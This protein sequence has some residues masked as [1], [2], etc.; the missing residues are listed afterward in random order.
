MLSD[1][2]ALSDPDIERFLLLRSTLDKNERDEIPH[3]FITNKKDAFLYWANIYKQDKPVF[4]T[5]GMVGL[6]LMPIY[7]MLK[8]IFM[9]L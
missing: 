1:F 3:P 5:L 9:F 8:L 7:W 4:F 2:I 6:L